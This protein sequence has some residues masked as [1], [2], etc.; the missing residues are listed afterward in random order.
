M[1]REKVAIS[2]DIVRDM[3]KEIDIRLI[4]QLRDLRARRA[5]VSQ[6]HVLV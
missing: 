5:T 1:E 6:P 2:I 4:L 3:I